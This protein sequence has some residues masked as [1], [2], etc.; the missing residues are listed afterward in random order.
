MVKATAP[1]AARGFLAR[2]RGDEAGNT[3][4]IFAAAVIPT[5]GLIGG[6]VDMSRI[7]LV[8]TSLQAACDAGSL[9]GRKTMAIGNWADDNFQARTEANTMFDAN[10]S[11]GSYGSGNLNRTFMEN[12]AG[13]VEGTASARLPMSL[14]KVLGNEAVDIKVTCQSELR[15]PNTD[16]MFVLDTTGSMADVIPGATG[17]TASFSKIKGLK[18]A[19][20][21][22]YEALAKKNITQV[23]KAECGQAEDPSSTKS[24]NTKVRFGFVPYAVNV[25]VGKILPFDFMANS[26]T[27]QS[28]Q[29]NLKGVPEYI[30]TYGTPHSPTVISTTTSNPKTGGWTANASITSIT[31]GGTVYLNSYKL[32]NSG[33]NC[34]APPPIQPDTSSTNPVL[35][36]QDPSDP[37]YPQASAIA[38]LSSSIT[39]GN[40]EYRYSKFQNNSTKEF[41]CSLQYRSINSVTTTT[42]TQYIYPITWNFALP[43]VNWTYKPV[44][45]DI[46]S[47]KNTASN[48]WNDS[49]SLPVGDNGTIRNVAW[50]G[51]IEERQTYQLTDS[52]PSNDWDPIPSTALDMDVDLVPDPSNTATQW[53]PNL[54]TAAYLRLLNNVRVTENVTTTLNMNQPSGN[55]ANCPT[56]AKFYQGWEPDDYNTYIESLSIGG[57]TYHD[58]GLLWGARLMSPTGI[59]ASQTAPANNTI[60]RHMIF[61]TDGKTETNRIDYNAYGNQWYDRRQTDP[62]L[63]PLNTLL[64]DNVNARSAAICKTIKSKN[65][66][67]WVIYYG[68]DADTATK[69]RLTECATDKRFFEAKDTDKLI[70]DFNTI[71]GA[72]SNLRLTN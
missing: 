59:F 34:I 65:I 41:G 61:M 19:V 8:K 20:K 51:C 23:T 21:C 37:T 9:T 27:Y 25:N 32:N 31:I 7:Y 53:A 50:Q 67:L 47:L 5:I 42:I 4:A 60:Q 17:N 18:L 3:I 30:R 43:F 13:N 12:G 44:T 72:I 46:S 49:I 28:R 58:I 70:S 68:S 57:N 10:F 24:D 55:A 22:F 15:I 29:A 40:T 54:P 64:T 36:S 71:A 16:V 2:L 11:S 14:M 1:A 38:N 6:A 45:F 33:E 48:T 69:N 52:D 56:E 66:T 26:W 39:N 63:A 35:I 62:S